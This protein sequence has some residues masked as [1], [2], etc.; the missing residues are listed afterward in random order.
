MKINDK[1]KTVKPEHES[2][3]W[4]PEALQSRKW[5]VTGRIKHIHNG[6]GLCYTVRHDDGTEGAYDPNELEPTDEFI[7]CPQPGPISITRIT[8]DSPPPADYSQHSITIT[9]NF[10]AMHLPQVDFNIVEKALAESRWDEGRYPFDE[11]MI[12]V[13]LAQVLERAIGDAVVLS[14]RKK[15]GDKTVNDRT[16]ADLEAQEIMRGLSLRIID[17]I[18]RAEIGRVVK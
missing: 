6:H 7:V 1:V 11:E 9:L 13:G 3:D 17:S 4:T 15:H 5:G 14:V 16:K 10:D 12:H 18:K 2:D 8:A